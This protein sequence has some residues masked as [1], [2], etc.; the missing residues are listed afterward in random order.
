MGEHPVEY[1]QAATENITEPLK[2]QTHDLWN[3]I[4]R[5]RNIDDAANVVK[6]HQMIL[7][8][9]AATLVLA[10]LCNKKVM[11]K[12]RSASKS[13][14]SITTRTMSKMRNACCGRSSMRSLREG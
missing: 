6:G 14:C 9:L 2:D 13:I 7:M 1:V 11:K 4:K 5:M 3:D 12:C 10:T 8:V